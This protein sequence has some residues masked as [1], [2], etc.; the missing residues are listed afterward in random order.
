VTGLVL[1]ILVQGQVLDEGTL[2]V[3]QD[4]AEVAREAFRLTLGRARAGG[5]GSGTD[6][7]LATSIRYDRVRPVIV[8]APILEVGRDTLPAAL[9]YDIADPREPV[10]ILGQLGGGRFTVRFVARASER[11]REFPANGRTVVLDDSVFAF[12]VFVAWRAGPVPVTLT[13]IV[14]RGLRRESLV[15]ADLG[16]T[17]TVL[18]RDP[19]ELR[20]ITVTGGANGL[21]HLWLD[22]AGRLMKVEIPSRQFTIERLPGG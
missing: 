9:Q 14:A 13:A 20:H 3:R 17:A 19:A 6:W 12:Y 11:A 18:N 16:S 7:T 2:V 21:V 10:R 5:G 8:L 4:T 15:V 22:A 1:A